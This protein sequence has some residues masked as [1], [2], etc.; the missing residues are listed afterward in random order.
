MRNPE[1]N[2]SA[3]SCCL[4]AFSL[5][6]RTVQLPLNYQKVLGRKVLNW[7]QLGSY[8]EHSNF[9]KI[10]KNSGYLAF[11]PYT[12]ADRILGRRVPLP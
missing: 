6:A 12:Q 7:K 5:R 2:G 9:K 1:T 10:K 4:S 11:A 8:F 3:S